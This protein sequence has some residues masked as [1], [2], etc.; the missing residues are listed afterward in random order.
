MGPHSCIGAPDKYNY[1][2]PGRGRGGVDRGGDRGLSEAWGRGPG[3]GLSEAPRGASNSS[4]GTAGFTSLKPFLGK[5][6]Y[7]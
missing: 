6:C 1:E 3:R 2:A 5:P 7:T 4:A